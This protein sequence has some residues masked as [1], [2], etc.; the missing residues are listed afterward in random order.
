[1]PWARSSK[2]ALPLPT[3]TRMERWRLSPQKTRKR[4][5]ARPLL[6]SEKQPK[7]PRTPSP[8]QQPE[9]LLGTHKEH[10]KHR[11]HGDLNVPYNPHSLDYI[12][13]HISTLT[14]PH[15]NNP[16]KNAKIP[17]FLR[18]RRKTPKPINT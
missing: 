11:V 10:C 2:R 13:T 18:K 9:R 14:P 8:A 4:E 1:M 17:P 5:H 15:P 6:P 12:P 7:I 3:N 16:P